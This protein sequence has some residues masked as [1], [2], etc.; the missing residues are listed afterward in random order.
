MAAEMSISETEIYGVVTFY[1]F[2][3]FSPRAGHVIMSCEGTGCYVRG[4]AR[5]R[6]AIENRLNVGPGETTAKTASSPSSRNLSAWARVTSALWWT[7]RRH[8][9]RTS[10]L[11]R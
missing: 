9:T 6:E 5:V 2:F 11:K 3:R 8:I 7:S 1:S 10:R 4:A